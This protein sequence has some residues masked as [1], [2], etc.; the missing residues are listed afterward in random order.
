MRVFWIIG[1]IVLVV[2]CALLGLVITTV[3]N[4]EN[5]NLIYAGIGFGAFIGLSV[6]IILWIIVE[7][8]IN[9]EGEY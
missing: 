2:L 5:Q 1:I 9:D 7:S 4:N 6:G 8:E 3:V